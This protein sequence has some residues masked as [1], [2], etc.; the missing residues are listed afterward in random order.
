M[1]YTEAREDFEHFMKL[2]TT[3]R[4]A[5]MDVVIEALDRRTPKK[6]IIYRDGDTPDDYECPICGRLYSIYEK[7]PDYCPDCGQAYNWEEV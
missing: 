7:L 3:L 4:P 6:L 1:T 5:F 2:K